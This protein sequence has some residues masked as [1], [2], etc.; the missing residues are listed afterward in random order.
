[1]NLVIVPEDPGDLNDSPRAQPETHSNDVL[2]TN[3]DFPLRAAR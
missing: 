2:S 1:M 3:P